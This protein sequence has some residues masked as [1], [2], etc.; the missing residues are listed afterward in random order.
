MLSRGNRN[1]EAGVVVVV[2]V[3][4]V[5]ALARRGEVVLASLVVHWATPFVRS[6]SV[7]GRI[8]CGVFQGQVH[9]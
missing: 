6:R 7:R 8:S 1:A 4:D 9:L 5:V 3:V 2:V